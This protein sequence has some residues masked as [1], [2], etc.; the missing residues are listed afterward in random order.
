MQRYRLHIAENIL[1]LKCQCGIAVLDFEACFAIKCSSC[2]TNFC[3][4][5]MVGCGNSKQC[6]EHV[7]DCPTAPKHRQGGFFGRLEE[8]NAVHACRRLDAV[9]TYLLEIEDEE[10]R[11]ALRLAILKD[12]EALGIVD[13]TAPD[14]PS[15]LP[16]IL[17]EGLIHRRRQQEGVVPRWMMMIMDEKVLGAIAVSLSVVLM[18]VGGALYF[19]SLL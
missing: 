9:E 10:D 14:V 1:T 19:A 12:L 2:A 8:F 5:C 6:H 17:P 16:V 15:H 3:G 7:R 4:W 11:N 18:A 13:M